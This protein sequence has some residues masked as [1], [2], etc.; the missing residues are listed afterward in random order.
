VAMRPLAL[1]PLIEAL[2]L[3]ASTLLGGAL[4]YRIVRPWA[5][6]RPWVGLA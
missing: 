5:R 3:I 4:F 2:V 6:L 1:A